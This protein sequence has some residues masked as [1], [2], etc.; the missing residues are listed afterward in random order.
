MSAHEHRWGTRPWSNGNALACL[1]CGVDKQSSA[2]EHACG[3]DSDSRRTDIAAIPTPDVTQN[4]TDFV[5]RLQRENYAKGQADATSALMVEI[6]QLRAELLDTQRLLKNE[7]VNYVREAE[8]NA[9]LRISTSKLLTAI[10]KRRTKQGRDAIG[11]EIE[12]LAREA[13]K[14]LEWK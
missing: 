9:R 12:E 7:A 10:D 2:A 4:A 14:V 13:R 3:S 11:C 1:N 6:R 5:M 8:D